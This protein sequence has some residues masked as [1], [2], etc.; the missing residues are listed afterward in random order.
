MV[1]VVGDVYEVI[2]LASGYTLTSN[3][4]IATPIIINT[5]GEIT[6]DLGTYSL[7]NQT[8]YDYDACGKNECYVFEVQAGT[9]NISGNGSVNAIGG[10]DYDMAVFANGTGKVNISGGKF[11][12]QG[13][14]NDG[15]DLI[16]VRDNAAV[17]ISGGEFVAGNKSSDVS[18]QYVA[19]NLRDADRSTASITVTGGKYYE[20]DPANNVSEGANTSF[21][22]EGYSSAKEGEY[23]VVTKSI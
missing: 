20:F 11:T 1:S 14:E 3:I 9:L 15:C 17:A 23:Y 22:A 5:T 7:T 10:S 4:E 16:Y 12:N 21:V 18:G 8:A 2:D 6:L 19:L 13:Q